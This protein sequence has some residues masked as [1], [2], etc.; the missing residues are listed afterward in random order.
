MDYFVL[1]V[2]SLILFAATFFSTVTGFGFALI[3]APV[4]TLVMGPKETVVFVIIAGLL[5]RVVMMW[6]TWGQFE[7]STVLVTSLGSFLGI[8]PG[9]YLLKVADA[10][11]LKILLGVAL[12]LVTALME[13]NFV[14][15][16]KNKNLG[17]TAAGFLSGFFSAATSISGPPIALYFLSEKMEKTLMRANM[18]WIFAIGGFATFGSFFVAGT[19]QGGDL[20]MLS[21]CVLPTVLLGWWLGEK[22]FFRINQHLFKR[23]ALLVVLAGGIMTLFSGIKGIWY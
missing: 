16:V 5:V 9:A 15:E 21:L 8:I 20:L 13:F 6:R 4:L 2:A 12:L 14:P 18:I 11:H 19:F 17:R 1:F 3:A 7:W 10:N 23:I 22:M